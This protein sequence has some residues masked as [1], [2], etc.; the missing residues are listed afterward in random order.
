MKIINW[1]RSTLKNAIAALA[2]CG[3]VVSGNHSV[4]QA[5]VTLDFTGLA[6][7]GTGIPDTYGD[8]LAGAPNID[9]TWNSPDDQSTADGWDS[10]NSWDGRGEV[11]QC[12][13]NQVNPMTITLTPDS[14]FGAF[15]TS[16]FLDEFVGGGDS[17]IQWNLPGTGFSGTWD[18]FGDAMGGDGGRTLITTGMTAGDA[19]AGPLVL[20]LTLDSGFG[21]YQALDNLTFGQVEI[22][23]CLVGDINLD[24][25]VNLQDVNPFVNLITGGLFQCEADVNA[26]GSVN[27]S[28]VAPFVGLLSGG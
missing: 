6:G 22:A 15:V 26:D 9:V 2:A 13:F 23:D 11:G 1:K 4:V 5:D 20:E 27:L 8:N 10:Y 12:D 25:D 16:F 28:D 17:I 14:G 24:G 21:S 19:V 3:V 7:N 18:E